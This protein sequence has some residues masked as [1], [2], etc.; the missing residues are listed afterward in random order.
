MWLK[1]NESN[2]FTVTVTVNPF[3]RF[4]VTQNDKIEKRDQKKLMKVIH[5]PLLMQCV[6]ANHVY[7]IGLVAE[8]WIPHVS[9]KQTEVTGKKQNTN[10][11]T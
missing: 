7:S 9:C 10:T 5:T 3:G 4:S 8:K 11:R 2:D 6:F 1:V